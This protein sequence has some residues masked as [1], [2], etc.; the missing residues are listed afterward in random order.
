MAG[1]VLSNMSNP[2]GQMA[3]VGGVGGMPPGYH[4]G[5]HHF[6]QHA[7][8]A[9]APHNT[10][11]DRP[12]KCDTCKAGFNRNH[13]LKRH[14]KIHLAVKPFPCTYCEKSFS[15]KDALKRHRLVKGCG[16]GENDSHEG[17]DNSPPEE[18]KPEDDDIPVSVASVAALRA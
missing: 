18:I 13:D 7:M 4:P 15:R 12:F 8:Y 6:G 17:N 14:T 5:Q 11:S 1:P 16:R 10:H 3:I 9:A 2:G